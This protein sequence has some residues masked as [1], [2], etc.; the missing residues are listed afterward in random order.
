MKH[1]WLEPS[2]KVVVIRD[3]LL[4]TSTCWLLTQSEV[5]KGLKL[6][7]LKFATDCWNIKYILYFCW[8]TRNCFQLALLVLTD[9]TNI[10]PRSPKVSDKQ[11]N[12]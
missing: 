3:V 9:F 10:I 8:K 1:T 4:F 7:V 6:P 12:E 5:E 2:T 11:N